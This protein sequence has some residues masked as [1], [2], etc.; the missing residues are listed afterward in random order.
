MIFCVLAYDIL[1]VGLWYFVCWLMVF[2]LSAYGILCVGLWYFVCWLT[3]FCVL[4]YGI[5]K[6]TMTMET[7]A[8]RCWKSHALLTDVLPQSFEIKQTQETEF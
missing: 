2:C 1:C 3:V 7:V 4:A 8:S 5:L 6:C